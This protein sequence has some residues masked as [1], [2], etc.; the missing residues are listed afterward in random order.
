MMEE[1]M[2]VIIL[3]I[4]VA[5]VVF[6]AFLVTV[7]CINSSRLSQIEE[8]FKARS[9]RSRSQARRTSAQINPTS[10]PASADSS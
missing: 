3:G 5:W 1:T 9:A 4:V 8:P 6:S 7:I 10:I 2:A